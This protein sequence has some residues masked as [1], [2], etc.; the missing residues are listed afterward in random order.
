MPRI[1]QSEFNVKMEFGY[2]LELTGVVDAQLVVDVIVDPTKTIRFVRYCPSEDALKDFMRRFL[3]SA[4]L[5]LKYLEWNHDW[6]V[7]K[8]GK[9]KLNDLVADYYRDVFLAAVPTSV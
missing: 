2:L 5:E 4:K 6:E 3:R 8:G 7:L 9:P 1:A